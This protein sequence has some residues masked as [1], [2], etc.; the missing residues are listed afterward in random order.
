V[1]PNW[2]VNRRFVM[3]QDH[4]KSFVERVTRDPDLR[5]AAMTELEKTASSPQSLID[6]GA[7]HGLRFN[8]AE[9]R[10]AWEEQRQAIGKGE[11]SDA[12]LDGVAGGGS[13]LSTALAN[14]VK[15]IGE[16]LSTAARKG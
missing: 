1:D 14:T 6:L 9:L 10:T 15:A 4:A 13:M 2:T 8:E 5:Q 16:A 7:R 12:E 11:L 3:S